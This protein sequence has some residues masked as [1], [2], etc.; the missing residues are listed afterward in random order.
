VSTA[1]ASGPRSDLLVRTVAGLALMTLALFAIAFGDYCFWALTTAAVLI[2][3]KEF[4]ALLGVSGWPRL[5]AMLLLTAVFVLAQPGHQL[6]AALPAVGVLLAIA[7]LL[8]LPFAGWRGAAGIV[9]A[10]VPGLALLFIR[11]QYDGANLTLWTLMIVWATDIGA[12]FAG[13][14]IG[15]PKLAPRLS[16]K[17]T[18]AGL[19]G[20]MAAALIV[21]LAVA[22][23]LHTPIRLAA[24]GS[25]LALLAQGGDLFESWLK[26][27]AGVKDSGKL[28]PGHGG[29]LDRLDGVVPVASVVAGLLLVGYV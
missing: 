8:A 20:G 13:R 19:I 11:D 29:A 6:I 3:L 17:K 27:R 23:W 10:G 5:G 15:G 28:L 14:S 9:Y 26:R 25:S 16:P 22:S 1:V 4:C 7:A 2:M 12:Y 18:W 24:L 21:S